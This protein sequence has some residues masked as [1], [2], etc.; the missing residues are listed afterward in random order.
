MTE[1][2]QKFMIIGKALVKTVRK[3]F[4]FSSNLESLQENGGELN[5]VSRNHLNDVREAVRLE[6]KKH[7]DKYGSLPIENWIPKLNFSRAKRL[8]KFG[9]QES[10][11][12]LC[13]QNSFYLV[14]SL[15]LM[16]FL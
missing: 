6:T 14:F 12:E 13:V 8:L 10:F 1:I 7:T 16:L 4:P 11:D 9:E 3:Y 2:Q 15:I 5:Q